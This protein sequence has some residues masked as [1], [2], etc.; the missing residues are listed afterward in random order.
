MTARRVTFAS[1]VV[2]VVAALAS[3]VFLAMGVGQSTP[4]DD[5]VIGAWG[6]LA[7]AFAALAFGTVGALVSNRIPDNRIGWIFSYIGLAI[8]VG[9]LGY[10]YA[11]QALFGSMQGLPGGELAAWSQN[12]TIPPCFGLI[13]VALML[14]P[15][16]RLPAPRWRPAAILALTG[17]TFEIL[18]YAMRPGRL[19]APFEPVTNPVGVDGAFGLFEVISSIGWPFMGLGLVL[20]AAAMRRRSKRATGLERQQLKWITFAAAI[21]GVMIAADII[22]FFVASDEADLNLLRT[23]TL[24]IGFSI[25]PVAAGIAIL[26]YRLYDIDVVI[27]RTLVYGALTATLA[28]TYLGSILLLQLVLRTFTAGSGLAVAASTLATAALVRPARARIQEVVDRRFYRRKYD[29]AR[30]LNDFGARLRD[31]IDLEALQGDLR[32]VVAETVQPTH[33]T[34]WLRAKESK[35]VTIS[36]RSTRRQE[37]S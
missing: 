23:V 34:L 28:G 15:D 35:T 12:L 27:N 29:A 10:Q 24:G 14:F 32:S 4:G 2:C 33:V 20:A 8:A 25:I 16:G 21:A 37:S 26:R 13:A 18:G 1:W 11:D 30:T 17:S 3:L 7:F 9:D 31:E 22:S 19:D 5:F 36:G 6:G